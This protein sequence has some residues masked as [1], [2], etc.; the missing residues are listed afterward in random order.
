[1]TNTRCVLTLTILQLVI[2]TCSAAN[3]IIWRKEEQKFVQLSN[4]PQFAVLLTESLVKRHE[5]EN[6]R[7]M[8]GKVIKATFYETINMI[9]FINNDTHITGM[10][11][12]LWH[13]L[14]D[15]LNF[16]LKPVKTHSQ[17]IGDKLENGTSTG[18][19]A[20]L[21]N[22]QTDVILRSKFLSSDD[23]D[24]ILPIW[25]SNYH[26][27]VQPKFLYDN[28]WV[29]TLFSLTM[30]YCIIFLFIIMSFVGYFLQKISKN[31]KTK[32]RRKGKS[33]GTA[34]MDFSLN[35]HFF[36][37]FGMMCS[38]G[39]IPDAFYNQF[40]ILSFSKSIFAWLLM[41]AFS[42]NLIYRMANR[43]LML[44]FTDIDSLFNNTKY[45]LL[46]FRGSYFYNYL[47]DKYAGNE[48][49]LSR[50]HYMEI[51]DMYAH[52]CDDPNKYV[53]I[54][55]EDSAQTNLKKY[56]MLLPVGN[57]NETWV[58]SIIK[59]KPSYKK[60]INIALIRF[61]EI[62]L[63]DFL[64]NRWLKANVN[65]VTENTFKKIDLDQVYL[66]FLIL[67]CGALI[68]FTIF[69]LENII[70]CHEMRN[71]SRRRK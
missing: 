35:D 42:S 18:L 54:D 13:L 12:D 68:S 26:I 69:I 14:A 20:M 10:C 22:N 45:T 21:E 70:Y 49:I 15:Y 36:H 1:M 38:Q 24:Y 8:K 41:L 23:L 64:K 55:I 44:P 5:M 3:G 51:A 63:L 34:D 50:I 9:M 37:S 25:R 2:A 47:Q 53:L 7:N 48:K 31:R 27:Y 60:S 67:C 66:I 4:I 61:Y 59:K 28:K 56:C 33:T 32:R 58:T 19:I 17:I 16:T 40:K 65:T 57:Y 29:F 11:G 46:I 52:V 62:G 39:Y 30:W 71:K 43:K 6:I